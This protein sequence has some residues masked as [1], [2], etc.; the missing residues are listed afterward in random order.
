MSYLE[1]TYGSLPDYIFTVETSCD[2]WRI[3]GKYLCNNK[4]S[5]TMNDRQAALRFLLDLGWGTL[6]GKQVCPSC[7]AHGKVS[8]P[9]DLLGSDILSK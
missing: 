5:V 3:R 1:I 2:A 8:F 9:R 7:Q 4:A 6:R